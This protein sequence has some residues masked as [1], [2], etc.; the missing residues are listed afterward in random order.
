MEAS[1]KRSGTACRAHVCLA[2]WALSKIQLC[3]CLLEA[4]GTMRSECQDLL[5]GT[6]KAI[7]LFP[8]PRY[9][10]FGMD[11][12]GLPS[13]NSPPQQPPSLIQGIIPVYSR[14]SGWSHW[15]RHEIKTEE[16]MTYQFHLL[17]SNKCCNPVDT[18]WRVHGG[19]IEPHLVVNPTTDY[20]TGRLNFA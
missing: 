11:P 4:P 13:T 6:T 18:Q 9:I 7:I 16:N 10:L 19:S 20:E 3:T 8:I 2:K 12:S 14:H 1:A 15:L 17:R 5:C